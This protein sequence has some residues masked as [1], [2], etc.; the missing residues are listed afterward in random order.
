LVEAACFEVRLPWLA[1]SM[2]LSNADPRPDYPTLVLKAARSCETIRVA[3]RCLEAVE[4]TEFGDEK[5][6]RAVHLR[7]RIRIAGE[8]Q[9]VA[10]AV[11]QAVEMQPGP[12][13]N[14][15]ERMLRLREMACLD[16]LLAAQATLNQ[17]LARLLDGRAKR[18]RT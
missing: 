2:N 16:Q 4:A 3:V 14:G 9:C 12:E 5:I 8:I 13:Q 7:A 17:E 10:T 15:E 18:P 6:L 11:R 1:I